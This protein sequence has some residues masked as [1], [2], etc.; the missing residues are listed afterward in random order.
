VGLNRRLIEGIRLAVFQGQRA[1]GTGSEAGTQAIAEIFP[2]QF[3]LA[4]HDGEG[5]LGAAYHAL[6]ASVAPFFVDPNDQS[7]G[8]HKH[9]PMWVATLVVAL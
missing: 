7:P 1:R 8:F 2:D 6:T 4:I 9:A 5:A 3:R